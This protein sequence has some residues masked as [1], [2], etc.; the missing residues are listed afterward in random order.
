MARLHLLRLLCF[1]LVGGLT[2]TCDLVAGYGAARI[3]RWKEW[4]SPEGLAPSL[5]EIRR[6]LPTH[7]AN[8][9]VALLFAG[10]WY[11]KSYIRRQL[12]SGSW[13]QVLFS[14][15][16]PNAVVWGGCWLAVIGLRRAVLDRL[17]EGWRHT[18]LVTWASVMIAGLLLWTQLR[19]A[20]PA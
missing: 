15:V 7:M 5:T 17:P 10:M 16:L 3:A 19:A 6:R 13:D 4:G 8:M 9:A 11:E 20:L 18:G 14:F 1:L 12:S 2:F